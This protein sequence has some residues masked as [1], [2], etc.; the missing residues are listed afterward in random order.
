MADHLY[1]ATIAWRRDGGDFARGRY[2]RDHVWRFEGGV[3]VPASASAKIVP[4]GFA[5]ENAVDPEQ[6]FVASLSA[7]HMLTFVD[8]ARRAG[9]STA[10]VSRTLATPERVAEKSR[11][12]VF[13][14]VKATGYTPNATARSL[15]ARSTRMVLAL[16]HG[17]GDPFYSEIVYAVEEVL[18]EAGYGMLVGDTHGDPRRE[19]H[20][21][22]LVRSGQV[23]G[24]LLFSGRLPGADFAALDAS[25]PIMLICNDIAQLS[26]PVVEIAN[27]DAARTLVEHL[28]SVGHRR[29]AHITGTS[30]NVEAAERERGYCDALEAAGLPI[31]RGLIWPGAFRPNASD[32]AAATRFVTMA[33]P[34][35]AVFVANDEN[36]IAFV[37]A[38]RD[39]GVSVP[40]D[41]SVAGFDDIGYAALLEPALTT[42]HQP[43]AALGRSAAELLVRRMTG[44]GTVPRR[45]RLACSLVVRDS[46]APLA[47]LSAPRV[48]DRRAEASQ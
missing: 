43:R 18:F 8:V 38:L 11:A 27:R 48:R 34:P 45:T 21:D 2:S 35:T 40:R 41:V 22:R 17:V 15:R 36:A 46:V 9:V 47:T 42:M 37:K 33:R 6:A 30:G 25:I 14:A 5:D 12:A 32:A 10:T 4:K 29:I 39:L 3:E 7:C 24:V 31:D 23:D 44:T 28:I 20:Y 13:A 26:L 19:A 1:R 16:L